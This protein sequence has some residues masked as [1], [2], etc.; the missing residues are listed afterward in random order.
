MRSYSPDAHAHDAQ[1]TGLVIEPRQGKSLR[2][3]SGR[4]VAAAAKGDI[5][6]MS[7]LL[8]ALLTLDETPSRVLGFAPVSSLGTAVLRTLRVNING[9]A[10]SH[11]CSGGHVE[12]V[13]L[14]LSRGASLSV[15][16]LVGAAAN[17]HAA[18]LQECLQIFTG[19]L[20][21]DPFKA[22]ASHGQVTAMRVL[23]EHQ[24]NWQRSG[25]YRE[26]VLR[27]MDGPV[28]PARADM[29]LAVISVTRT[30]CDSDLNSVIIWARKPPADGGAEAL[31]LVSFVIT[32]GAELRRNLAPA[33]A[34]SLTAAELL[35]LLDVGGVNVATAETPNAWGRDGP[36]LEAACSFGAQADVVSELLR[37]GAKPSSEALAA[38][39]RA[40]Q[41][42]TTAT[43]LILLDAGANPLGVVR[44][45]CRASHSGTDTPVSVAFKQGLE[46]VVIAMLGRLSYS[47]DSPPPTWMLER[48]AAVGF[49]AAC[50]KL[51][52]Q[53]ASP[54][55]SAFRAAVVSGSPTVLRSLWD[56]GV[57]SGTVHLDEALLAATE[58]SAGVSA[59]TLLYIVNDLGARPTR[60]ILAC[61]LRS[62]SCPGRDDVVKILLRHSDG[63]IILRLNS[64]MFDE[65]YRYIRDWCV[66]IDVF[67]LTLLTSEFVRSAI[68][69][70]PFALQGPSW[71]FC[72]A[73]RCCG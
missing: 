68:R 49:S 37:R 57:T 8:N 69:V 59:S 58:F 42:A 11:A 64:P 41:G 5:P 9:T 36:L 73:R 24:R 28:S 50:D 48:A 70:Y 52:Q 7:F 30:L 4:L 16:Q 22:A 26:V 53:G 23:L 35:P 12:A 21:A 1:L 60:Q 3:T 13:R 31:A 34:M 25:D 29:L 17:G 15:D 38:A 62:D 10:L 44:E 45:G 63:D 67:D 66:R 18:L 32:R 54:T 71:R 2:V 27:C 56:K 61:A 65:K 39:L 46:H 19:H 72:G 40:A 51:L 43:A 6:R 14:L 47:S 20:G 33:A 55:H